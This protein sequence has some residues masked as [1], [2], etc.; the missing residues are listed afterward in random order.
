MDGSPSLP[1][2]VITCMHAYNT[3]SPPPH[4]P[5]RPNVQI[6]STST[7]ELDSTVKRQGKTAGRLES[8]AGQ[9]NASATRAEAAMKSYQE[10]RGVLI[11][12]GFLAW[13]SK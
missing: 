13:C 12:G 4:T 3:T 1:I 6:V 8:V 11:F 5:R 9:L 2:R 7:Q 10:V